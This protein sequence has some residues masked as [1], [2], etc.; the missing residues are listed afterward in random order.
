MKTIY[1]HPEMWDQIR[2]EFPTESDDYIHRLNKTPQA[3]LGSFCLRTSEF[4]PKTQT[5]KTGK[6]RIKHTGE[7]VNKEKIQIEYKLWTYGPEDL[8]WLLY[9]GEV[10]EE[11][12]ETPVVFILDDKDFSYDFFKEKQCIGM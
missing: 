6:Y 1:C 5:K 12:S 11:I 10:E 2:K 4:I 7:I 9:T 3:Y 8:S